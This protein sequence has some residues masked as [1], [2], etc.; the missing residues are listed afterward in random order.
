MAPADDTPLLLTPLHALHVALGA[1]MVPF[2]GYEMP[3]QYK[4]G[5]IAEHLH[6]RAKAGLFDVSHMGQ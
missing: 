3:V 1:R 6:T 2:A 5:I 4:A